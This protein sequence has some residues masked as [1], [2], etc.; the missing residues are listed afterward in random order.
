MGE[1]CTLPLRFLLLYLFFSLAFLFF[2]IQ[3][4]PTWYQ[5]QGDSIGDWLTTKSSEGHCWRQQVRT[6]IGPEKVRVWFVMIY[7]GFWSFFHNFFNNKKLFFGVFYWKK[8]KKSD[9]IKVLDLINLEVFPELDHKW[10]IFLLGIFQKVV[11]FDL[12]EDWSI[13]EQFR[14]P[15]VIV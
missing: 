13:S 14:P 12:M 2:F 3:Y 10:V 1:E 15:C 4:S 11:W 8:R 6:T 5:S 9:L 7:Q